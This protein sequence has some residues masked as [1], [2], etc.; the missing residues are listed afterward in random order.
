LLRLAYINELT[1]KFLRL[2]GIG[3]KA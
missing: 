1:L 3:S 2:G